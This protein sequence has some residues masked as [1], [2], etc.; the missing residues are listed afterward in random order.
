[1]ISNEY[2]KLFKTD[3]QQAWKGETMKSG[4]S[5]IF[6]L[7][8]CCLAAL[9]ALFPQPLRAGDA[10]DA[11]VAVSVQSNRSAHLSQQ[12][13][14]ALDDETRKMFEQYR[15]VL[16]QTESLRTYNDQLQRMT[17]SQQKEMI[18]LERQ[19]ADIAATHR[20]I[21]PLM[22]RMVASLESFVALDVP[23]LPE[24]RKRRIEGLHELMDRSDV[25]VSEKYRRILEA[26]QIENDYGRTIEG[27]RADLADGGASRT[28]DFLRLGRV[29]LFYQSLDGREVGHWD[30]A[31]G[32]W[33]VLDSDYRH[34]IR[35]G[36]RIARKQSAPDLLILPISAPEVIR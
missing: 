7:M 26:Y 12:K 24:E 5:A 6:L 35:Q 9:Q 27:Y 4:F 8:A 13:I 34:P 19:I 32:R 15:A 3:T 30:R 31:S 10:L 22:L 36:L 1:M 23:F 17:E 11:A 2:L 29:G 21:V 28:V 25:S 18:S 16:R 20:E 33:Q 14:D